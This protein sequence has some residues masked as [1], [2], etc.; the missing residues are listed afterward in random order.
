MTAEEAF[1][2]ATKVRAKA[3]AYFYE[4]ME[5]EVGA[6][7]AEKIFT[8]VTYRL[9]TDNANAMRNEEKSSVTAVAK[10]F[11]KEGVGK[12]VFQQTLVD[13]ND[14]KA[15]VK[16]EYCP[17]VEA[18]REMGLS[19]GRIKTLCDMAYRIDFGTLE[20]AGYALS[21]PSRIATGDDCCT[22]A[23]TKKG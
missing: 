2:K 10:T 13:A 14:E 9:G 3:Y 18:W 17:L 21:F 19:V 4:E 6:E 8:R 12:N 22:L 15:E 11:T 16:M 5:N 1:I 23:I 20:G 7:V